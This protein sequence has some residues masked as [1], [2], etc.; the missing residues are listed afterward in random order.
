MRK[1]IVGTILGSALLVAFL[2][3]KETAIAEECHRSDSCDVKTQ[4]IDEKKCPDDMQFI[5]GDFC[6]NVEEIC[7]Y[8]VDA[9]GK[10]IPGPYKSGSCGEYKYPTR[11]LS[12]T[13][14]HKRFCIDRFEF[15]NKEGVVPRDWM[16]WYEARD[17]AAKI[18]KRLCTDS[19]WTFAAEGQEMRP[20]PYGD[21][22][23][24]NS[25]LCNIDRHEK[26]DVFHAKTPHSPASEMLR[27]L[28][29]PSGSMPLCVS[30]TGVHDMAGNIDEF[31]INE[32]GKPYVSALK[33][34]HIWHV[35]QA[36]RPS[37][38]AHGPNFAWYETGTRFCQDALK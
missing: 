18:G 11:C 28:L 15:P 17:E 34:G 27:S 33:G 30:S 1:I 9:Y 22:Y 3:G 14:I 2:S 32:S 38:L 25:G 16:T 8:G 20:L 21:G 6:P 5:E 24:R 31:V 26:I 12:T 23:H 13:K 35:R 4:K 29:V 10:R 36:S 19:E 37:T 7:L